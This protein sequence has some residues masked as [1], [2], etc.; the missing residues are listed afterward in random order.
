MSAKEGYAP[1]EH[2]SK[3]QSSP[4][5][6][7]EG[8]RNRTLS[9]LKKFPYYFPPPDSYNKICYITN[10]PLFKLSKENC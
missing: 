7:S 10:V 6:Q 4:D 9:P 5:Q 1:L 2:Q 3:G 8:L